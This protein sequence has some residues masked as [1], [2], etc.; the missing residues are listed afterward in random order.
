[1]MMCLL[2]AGKTC[3]TKTK[4]KTERKQEMEEVIEFV[5]VWVWLISPVALAWYLEKAE[6]GEVK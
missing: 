3:K 5:I 1:M 4:T 6:K 2:R